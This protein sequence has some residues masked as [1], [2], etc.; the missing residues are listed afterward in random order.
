MNKDQ[1]NKMKWIKIAVA[2]LWVVLIVIVFI[3]R[4]DFS[5]SKLL[6]WKPENQFGAAL[7][8][9]LLFGL[10]SM[11]FFIYSGLLYLADGMFFSMP[12]AF[13][14]SLIGTA[15]MVSI[16]YFIGKWLGGGI[17]E[18]LLEKYPKLKTIDDLLVK[19]QFVA[20]LLVRV[21]GR[22]PSDVVSLYFGAN[23]F[24]YK[25]YLLSSVLCFVPH[26]IAYPMMGSSLDNPGSPEF[27][28]GLFFEL[29]WAVACFIGYF[30]Y[31][32]KHKSEPA[33]PEA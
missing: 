6:S 12:M 28:W 18:H 5:I 30:L 14:V 29:A 16:P 19:N 8:M 26:M 11:T 25:S 32:K 13:L 9:I 33:A 7:F 17:R 3:Y 22:L 21:I 23:H 1:N 10:K 24:D 2:S 4:E 27:L 15:V 20:V 31:R